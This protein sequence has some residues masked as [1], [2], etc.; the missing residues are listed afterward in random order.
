MISIPA[1]STSGL[2]ILLHHISDLLAASPQ[3]FFTGAVLAVIWIQPSHISGSGIALCGKEYLIIVYI[4]YSLGGINDPP[5]HNGANNHRIAPFIINMC[6]SLFRVIA[7]KDTFLLSE[8]ITEFGPVVRPVAA[9]GFT[10][11]Q[12][13][14]TQIRSILFQRAAIFAK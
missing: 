13:G 6:F 4:E 7:F 1:T 9:V 10:A 2:E 14:F 3:G 8:M 11:V 12:K 5:D